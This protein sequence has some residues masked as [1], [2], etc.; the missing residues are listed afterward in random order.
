MNAIRFLFTK[1]FAKHLL[2]LVGLLIVLVT[3]LLFWLDLNTR[4]GQKIQVPDVSGMTLDEAVSAL[5]ERELAYAILDTSNYNPN[6]PY[7]TII[8]Q[9]P[10]SGAQVK[11]SRKIYLS[12]N[13]SGYK[14]T[15]VPYVVGKTLRQ[16]E[17]ALNSSGFQIGD[18]TYKKYVAKDEVLTM[19]FRNRKIKQ[20][21]RL[22]RTSVIDLVLGDGTGGFT[23]EPL[24]RNSPYRSFKRKRDSL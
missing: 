5:Q 16:A 3:V 14:V 15:T 24:D 23:V 19:T 7:Q 20:G 12:I 10:E 1:T 6:Y 4:H 21:D 22:P 8:E 2:M 13:R 17:P 9:I 18:L 11:Q